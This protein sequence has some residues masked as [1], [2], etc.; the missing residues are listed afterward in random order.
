LKVLKPSLKE[1]AE[2]IKRFNT[3]SRAA[4]RL[5]HP[6]IVQ[7][8]DVGDSHGLDYIVMELVDGVPLSEC[9][10]NNGP[11]SWEKACEYALQIASALSCAHANHVIHRD[12]KPHNIL[13]GKDGIVKV[14]D[15]GIAQATTNE[16]MVA[17][18]GNM[19]GMGSIRY[20]SPEQVRGGFTDEQSDL[21]SLGVVLYEML[22]GKVPFDGDNPVSIAL[23]KLEK[24]PTDCKTYNRYIPDNIARFTMKAI[25]KDRHNR[26][27]TAEEMITSL[28]R[29]TGSIA[30]REDGSSGIGKKNGKKM[31]KSTK[32][33]LWAI[34]GVIALFVGTYAFMSS[35]TQEYEVPD[36]SN[37]TIEEAEDALRRTNLR[38]DGNIKYE[39][40][41]DVEKGLVISQ[42]PGINQYVKKGR[43]IK[44][45]VSSGT[46][47]DVI[48]TVKV[49]DV[50]NLIKE[51][52]ISRLEDS[53]LKCDVVEEF[54]EKI[55][56]G[57]VIRQSP[58]PSTILEKGSKVTIY[59][60][61][62]VAP[63]VETHTKVPKLVG[64]T[65]SQATALLEQAGLSLGTVLSEES[66]E[67]VGKII[68]Q[69]PAAG[70]E[71]EKGTAVSVVVSAGMKTPEPTL[72]PDP[73][74]YPGQVNTPTP[75]VPPVQTQAPSHTQ[76]HQPVTP[77]DPNGG[78]INPNTPAE[79]ERVLTINIPDTANEVVNVEVLVDGKKTYSRKHNKSEV[80][81]D[82]PVRS[83]HDAT[84]QV[85]IDEK[86]VVNRVIDF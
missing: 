68:T 36:L 32:Y 83:T 41:E 56:Y 26:F 55:Q 3:E 34:A 12:I 46:T 81:I 54:S 63:P 51:E 48:E 85:Y 20:S 43:K 42:N 64:Y 25:A 10:Q 27:Q 44:I 79:K 47:A 73:S 61:A 76:P 23:M 9:I 59:V 33:I 86:L 70:T 7:V 5:S 38:L 31:D 80:S 30:R 17:G 11:F 62:D 1:D 19:G 58:S 52:A 22:T 4:A 16:T 39:E 24:E 77:A 82:V 69:L 66:A 71:T 29:F 72:T 74:T 65:S 45:T 50:E 57:Y 15:F 60:S 8:F 14:A 21:Y 84:V 40:S 6:N 78:A 67:E 37:M 2:V 35:G 13:V 49:M 75:T 18:K 28:E 53:G